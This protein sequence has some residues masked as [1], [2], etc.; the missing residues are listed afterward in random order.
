MEMNDCT[1]QFFAEATSRRNLFR[2]YLGGKNG[3]LICMLLAGGMLSTA[4]R[5]GTCEAHGGPK[6]FN[7]IMDYRLDNPTE[8]TAGRTIQNAYQWNLN[9]DYGVVCACTGQ[10]TEAFIMAKVPDTGE[11][12]SD[13]SLHYFRIND[14]L[15]AAT[16]VFV[17]GNLG[18]NLPTP[19]PSTSNLQSVSQN[20][21]FA[22]YSTGSKGN[23]SLYFIRPFVGV[24][25]IPLTKLVDVYVA[26]DPTSQSSTPVSVVWMS[27]TVTVPQSCV[28]NG[29]GV[30]NVPFGDILSGNIATKGE[31]AKN[32]TPKTVNFD[33]ACTNISEGVKVSLTFQG[34]PDATDPTALATT[35]KDVGV[36]IQDPAGAPVA[37]QSG[38]LPLTMDYSSQVGTSAI[39]LF[40]FNTTGKAPETGDFTAT[41][42]I[43]AEIQ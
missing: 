26:T 37:P 17:G 1:N 8:N 6:A 13:G 36:R 22:V 5:A 40:P 19:F 28:I 12:Y 29:G 38:E 39:S 3:A 20:C 10:Y 27:G 15:A 7:F 14:Y 33:V 23:V 18:K 2:R 31:K 42:T 41:A 9:Q 32:F 30:I 43:R 24:Q 35:N 34:T 25:T 21:S 11:V 4:A 16:S